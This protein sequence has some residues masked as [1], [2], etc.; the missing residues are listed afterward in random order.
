MASDDLSLCAV[1]AAAATPKVSL[2]QDQHRAAVDHLIAQV[3]AQGPEAVSEHVRSLHL[4]DHPQALTDMIYWCLK[5]GW[6]IPQWAA[7]AFIVAVEKVR[8]AEVDS[9]DDAFGKPYP[10]E[11]I[12]KVRRHRKSTAIYLR[13]TELHERG[14]PIDTENMF[15]PVGKE[16]GLAATQC[17]QLYYAFKKREETLQAGGTSH[18]PKNSQTSEKI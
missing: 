2:A 15:A 11:H 3:L 5:L 1:G 17:K 13:V 4:S 8:F 16:F 10:G 12:G 9:W 18:F 6:P 7:D 14:T